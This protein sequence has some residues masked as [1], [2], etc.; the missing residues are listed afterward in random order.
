MATSFDRFK[1]KS[2]LYTYLNTRCWGQTTG[3][4]CFAGQ[5]LRVIALPATGNRWIL[6]RGVDNLNWI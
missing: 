5:L 2:P 6:I 1:Q 4:T 3:N